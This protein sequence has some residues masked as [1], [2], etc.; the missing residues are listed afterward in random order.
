MFYSPVD[1]TTDTTTDD[2]D[3]F[4]NVYFRILSTMLL[5]FVKRL[6]V[7]KQKLHKIEPTRF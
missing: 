1:V 7:H 5:V 2:P 4:Q 6:F 3:E